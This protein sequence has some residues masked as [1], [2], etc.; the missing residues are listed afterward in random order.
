MDYGQQQ[1]KQ[2]QGPRQGSADFLANHTYIR[3]NTVHLWEQA[4]F[5]V[6]CIERRDPR[7]Q[8]T[9]PVSASPTPSAGLVY[10]NLIIMQINTLSNKLA[11]YETD[12]QLFATH[13]SAKFKVTW[14]KN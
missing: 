13:V 4:T 14:K 7:P 3:Y 8:G 12:G 9:R 10:G 6:Y 1:R 2:V 5:N 11:L